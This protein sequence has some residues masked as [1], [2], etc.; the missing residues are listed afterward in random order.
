MTWKRGTLTL[1][2]ITAAH[3]LVRKLKQLLCNVNK[4]EN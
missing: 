3:E 1:S 4:G 2:R